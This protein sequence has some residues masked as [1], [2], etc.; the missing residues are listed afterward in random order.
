MILKAPAQYCN[1]HSRISWVSN[2][3]FFCTGT[4]FLCS[5]FVYYN[6]SLPMVTSLSHVHAPLFQPGARAKNRIVA[7]SFFRHAADL[8]MFFVVCV[9][10]LLLPAFAIAAIVV[11]ARGLFAA[12][13]RKGRAL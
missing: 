11:G 4:N 13:K 7:G 2:C 9:S 6:K 1:V 8:W 10:I 5:K 12:F 3:L